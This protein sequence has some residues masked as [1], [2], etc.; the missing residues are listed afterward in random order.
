MKKGSSFLVAFIIGLATLFVVAG[1]YAANTV[2]DVV[3]M[4]N[5]AYKAHKKGIVEFTHKKH[6][7][8]YGASC[9][10]CHHDDKGKP[11][12]LKEGDDVQ[13]CLAC[14]KIPS[15]VPKDI[16]KEWKA[17]KLKKAEINK[18]KLEYH[19]EALHENCKGCHKAFNKKN[20]TKKAPTTCAKCHPKLKK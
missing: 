1:V 13:N 11:L 6:V 9:G 7:D 2:P 16:K 3:K 14:H 4:D 12:N 20:K 17:K 5:P 18:L 15:E 19:A 10:E 8:E